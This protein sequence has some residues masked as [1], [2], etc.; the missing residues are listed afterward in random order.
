MTTQ[1]LRLYP[2]KSSMSDMHL[3]IRKTAAIQR[4]RN[5]SLSGLEAVELRGMLSCWGGGGREG[6]ASVT[7][8]TLIPV[9]YLL[10]R[11]QKPLT[12]LKHESL[13]PRHPEDIL[14]K[15]SVTLG[16]VRS[17]KEGEKREKGR[18]KVEGE[19][20]RDRQTEIEK[21]TSFFSYPLKYALNFCGL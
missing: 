17:R 2:E 9:S 19:G 11:I 6:N 15:T 13:V 1:K 18:R 21:I 7:K 3:K 20:E 16:F 5:C 12:F 14:A 8:T 4:A 10:P